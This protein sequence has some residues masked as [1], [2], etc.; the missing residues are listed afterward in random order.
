MVCSAIKISDAVQTIDSKGYGNGFDLVLL[1]ICLPLC[2]ES[3]MEPGV[4]LRL[5]ER[6]FYQLR[7]IV[8]R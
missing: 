8:S 2:R 1:D 4:D 3:K 5:I 6:F 7:Q